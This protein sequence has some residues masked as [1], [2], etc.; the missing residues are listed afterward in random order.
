MQELLQHDDLLDLIIAGKK[1]ATVR[2]G[3]RDITP[4]VLNLRSTQKSD[5]DHQ[6]LVNKVE[7]VKFGN[8]TQEHAEIDGYESVHDLKSRL[9]DIYGEL[10]DSQDMTI[11]YWD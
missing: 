4:S 10:D 3:R 8:L 7:V 2:K 6:V 5:K 11:V 9:K 1:H